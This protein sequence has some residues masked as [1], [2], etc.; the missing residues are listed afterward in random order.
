MGIYKRGK[1]WWM[2]FTYEGRRHRKS[3]QTRDRKLA[4]RIDD[5]VNGQIAENKYFPE[6]PGENK[7]FEEMVEKFIKE[8]I[9][10]RSRNPYLANVK[11]LLG[12]LGNRRLVEVSPRVITEFKLK[13]RADGVKPATINHE[14]VVLKRMFNLAC[15]EWEWLDKN[16]VRC[17]RLEAGVTK[18]DRWATLEEEDQLLACCW[19]ESK[20]SQ[21]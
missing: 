13:R 5:K 19:Q 7:N 20:G 8:N 18:R 4:Q 15:G 14:L 2:S 11:T 1:V 12:F 10:S 3:T 21:K 6:M 16:P 9:P 17:V